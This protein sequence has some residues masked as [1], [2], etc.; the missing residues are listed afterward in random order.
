[1]PRFRHPA[2]LALAL[3]VAVVVVVLAVVISAAGGGDGRPDYPFAVVVF[4][5]QGREHL[6]PGQQYDFYNSNPPTSGPHALAP[7][8]WGVHAEPVPKE[9]AV[10]NMEHGGVVIWYNCAAGDAPLDEPACDDLRDQLAAITTANIGDGKQILTIPYP[11]MDRRIALTA[12]RTLDAFDEFDPD[13]VQ[14]FIDS[15]ERAFNPEGF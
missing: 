12:W 3:V 1:M 5:D 7:A 8:D 15:F 9:V 11:Q 2:L 6:P 4:A 14:A 10:H 13:R